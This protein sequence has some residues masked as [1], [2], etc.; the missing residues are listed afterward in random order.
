MCYRLICERNK[1]LYAELERLSIQLLSSD[2]E[3]IIRRASLQER[4]NNIKGLINA[5]LELLF[6]N[7][8]T[9]ADKIDN[10]PYFKRIANYIRA[11]PDTPIPLIA[12]I[13][14]TKINTVIYVLNQI[15]QPYP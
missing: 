6:A 9:P 1:R 4:K 12:G 8:L 7:D 3:F 10:R 11:H 5:N 15:N 2:I 13:C 14:G